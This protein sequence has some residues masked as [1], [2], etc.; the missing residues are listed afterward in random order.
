MFSCTGAD[1]VSSQEVHSSRS[2][3]GKGVATVT[4][5][6]L[7]HS[8][9]GFSK[10]AL[11]FLNPLGLSDLTLVLGS[12]VAAHVSPHLCLS[13]ARSISAPILG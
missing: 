5:Y 11:H 1:C 9:F 2:G 4:L 3:Q 13:R 10:E 7:L 12:V 8:L 6:H